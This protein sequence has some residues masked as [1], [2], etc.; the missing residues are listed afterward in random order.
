MLYSGRI[1]FG[2]KTGTFHKSYDIELIEKK[3]IKGLGNLRY[4]LSKYTGLL[5]EGSLK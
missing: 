1:I 2:A 4:E 3:D 5:S